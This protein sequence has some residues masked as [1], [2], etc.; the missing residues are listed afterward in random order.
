MKYENEKQPGS[1]ARRFSIFRSLWYR[2]RAEAMDDA[3]AGRSITMPI[4]S[5]VPP[6]QQV[7]RR[8]AMALLVLAVTTLLVWFD[9]DGYNDNSDGSVDFLDAAYYAT[10]T[11]S[12]TGYGDIT[13]VSDAAR[14]TNIF[15]ITPL[16]VLF[17]IILVG[18]TLEV[19]TERTRQQVRVHRWR[20]NMRDHVVVVGYGTKGRQAIETLLGQGIRKDKIVVVDPQRKTVE[21]A[22]SDGLVSVLG[23]ATRSDT[24]RKAELQS[25]A[26]VIVAPQRD[27]TAALVT[28][29]ARQLNKSATIVAAVRE[30]ENV[31]LLKQSGADTVVT[32]SS[33]A[34]RLLGVSMASP[35]VADALEHLM[36]YGSGLD[37]VERPVTKDEVGRSPRECADLVVAVVR[38]KTV[39]DYTEPQAASLQ[40]RDRVISIR[41]AAST[42]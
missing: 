11:L 33:S 41:Q 8:L 22:S 32:S 19:L 42:S 4:E 37:L 9:R 36:T 18:T 21:A 14:L 5:S 1:K 30:D 34:G 28:L 26:Q 10:V 12:T 27:D 13:P 25:A 23:D 6:L 29:T 40:A 2:S 31:P 39:F 3:E 16:R 20:S 38:G 15:V 7:L 35:H 24:L 17:L